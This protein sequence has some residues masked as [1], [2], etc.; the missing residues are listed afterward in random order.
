M[1]ITLADREDE[2]LARMQVRFD[3]VARFLSYLNNEEGRKSMR[4]GIWLRW[5]VSSGSAN[6]PWAD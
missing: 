5:A 1:S 3:R 4:E 6:S 2:K